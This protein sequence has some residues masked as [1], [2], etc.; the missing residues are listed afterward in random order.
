[1]NRVQVRFRPSYIVVPSAIQLDLHVDGGVHFTSLGPEQS[2]MLKSRIPL[3][4]ILYS[5]TLVAKVLRVQIQFALNSHI[6]IYNPH[7][8]TWILISSYT[9]MIIRSQGKTHIF[10]FLL[11]SKGT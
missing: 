6:C 8:A 4:Y 2:S 7:P 1:M 11:L 5:K 9:M 10:F 3:S